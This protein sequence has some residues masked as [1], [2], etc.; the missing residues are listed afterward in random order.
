MAQLLTSG[1][2]S[3]PLLCPRN[4]DALLSLLS[5]K[6]GLVFGSAQKD[7]FTP[8]DFKTLMELLVFYI[9][10][11]QTDQRW[12]VKPWG[13][14][15]WLGCISKG[16]AREILGI[17]KGNADVTSAV[18]K[19]HLFCPT[20]SKPT[21]APLVL[22]VHQKNMKLQFGNEKTCPMHLHG[23]KILLLLLLFNS[24]SCWIW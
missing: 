15:K 1:F 24:A 8:R 19:V 11:L 22:S 5:I 4:V 6:V 18:T 7:R 14:L 20:R 3:C 10:C 13:F 23:R 2:L 16:R 12:S 21:G 17:R 9:F